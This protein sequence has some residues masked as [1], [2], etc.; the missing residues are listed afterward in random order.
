MESQIQ[1]TVE[2]SIA[3]RKPA[4]PCISQVS[5]LKPRNLAGSLYT[6][7]CVGLTG[8]ALL[9]SISNN[10]VLWIVGQV[11]LAV[12]LLQWFVLLHEAGHKTLFRS[13]RLNGYVGHLAAFF[14]GIPFECWKA[15]HGMHHHWTGW[16]D[17]D[18]TT[19]TLV[20]KKR[21]WWENFLVNVCWKLWIPVFSIVYRLSNYWHLPRLVRLFPRKRQRWRLT[22]NWVLLLGAYA[23]IIYLV[24][25]GSVL[26][27]VGIGFFLSLVIQ[28]P[29][30]LSQHTHIPMRLSHGE[31]VQPFAPAEQ[32]LFTRSLE[33]PSWFSTLVLLNM[34]AHEL[35][36]MYSGVPG[37][38]LRR[39]DYC[40]ENSMH[41]WRWLMKAKSV[42]GEVF[43][44]QNRNQ[45]GFDI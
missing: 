31:V 8:S 6:A 2:R 37:Y 22:G 12:A 44:F 29:L 45:S 10:L 40:T 34:D 32:E 26:R 36:H 4:P 1:A 27:L 5:H 21:A 15:I 35:H 42:P 11:M 38:D 19:V 18:A 33:F 9:L 7:F 30:I 3:E 13:V 41:W 39:I 14:A 43:L 25:A 20:P 16:Q 28:D 23:V 17:L 24:G